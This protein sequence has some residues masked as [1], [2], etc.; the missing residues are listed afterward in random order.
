MS[1]V[2]STSESVFISRQP[3]FDRDKAI[4]GYDIVACCSDLT[5][6]VDMEQLRK[7]AHWLLT[8]GL[9]LALHELPAGR[10]ALLHVPASLLALGTPLPP[11]DRC[12]LFI[13]MDCPPDEAFFS[14][15]QG[16]KN[17]G[18]MLF[19]STDMITSDL[20]PILGVAEAMVVDVAG[21]PPM[22]IAKLRK[23]FKKFPW[24]LLA[25]NISDWQAFEGTRFLGFTYFSGSFFGKPMLAAEKVLAPGALARLQLLRALNVP[26]CDMIELAD[27]VSHDA[28]LSLRLLKYINSPAFGLQ[29]KVQS[30]RN[31]ITL[32]GLKQFKQWAMVV[33]MADMDKSDKGGELSYLALLRARFL[34]QTSMRAVQAPYPSETMFLLGMF[35]FLD[36][37]LGQEMSKILSDMPLDEE[38][39][40]AL[41]G[42]KNTVRP[43]IDLVA[44]VEAGNWSVVREIVD[45]FE[46]EATAAAL[47]Y[48]KAATWARS[49]FSAA[50]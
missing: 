6:R 12:A 11:N 28:A 48:L 1:D 47:D 14:A 27:I 10:K 37:M 42:E 9:A 17:A 36:A 30:M 46:I 35:S 20:A 31:A 29:Q 24:Q 45:S 8:D 50:R 32:L 18:Y 15:C 23:S 43:W 41:C 5:C 26:E 22:E 49:N 13:F 34:E 2:A 7:D 21:L 38:L 40:A 33:L 3:I 19:L 44:N 4:W 25:R 16:L 39:K